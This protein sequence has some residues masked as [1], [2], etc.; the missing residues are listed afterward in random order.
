M[1]LLA[2]LDGT[3]PATFGVVVIV[4]LQLAQ[5]VF[6]W[7]KDM[8]RENSAKKEDLTA[9]R[10]EFKEELK[11]LDDKLEAMRTSSDGWRQGLESKLGE[12]SNRVASLG[13]AQD[14]MNQT[15]IAIRT[16]LDKLS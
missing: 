2:Q 3:N 6:A 4:L 13:T 8:A 12:V 15:L 11:E 10:K 14:L 7:K 16:K 9:L 1:M 5:F